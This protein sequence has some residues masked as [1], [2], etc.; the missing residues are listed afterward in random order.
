MDT[1]NVGQLLH[2][3]LAINSVIDYLQIG[4]LNLKEPINN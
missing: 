2:F 3:D 4:F 1:N